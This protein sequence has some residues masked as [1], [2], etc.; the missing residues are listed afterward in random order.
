M[1]SI[2]VLFNLQVRSRID[3]QKERLVRAWKILNFEF[4]LGIHCINLLPTDPPTQKLSS[5]IPRGSKLSHQGRP[6]NRY[7]KYRSFDRATTVMREGLI[8]SLATD[9]LEHIRKNGGRPRRGFFKQ[10]L[11]DVNRAAPGCHIRDF[12]VYNEQR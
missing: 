9:L 4:S 10:M 7:S 11:A 12:D 6:P 2:R 5:T 8:K 3:L 1:A